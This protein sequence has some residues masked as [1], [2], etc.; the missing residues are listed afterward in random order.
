[1][2]SLF[3]LLSTFARDESGQDIIEYAL[4]ATVIALGA[5]ASMKSVAT[6]IHAVF[7]SVGTTLTNAT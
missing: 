3:H 7:S 2:P 4:L 1:M 6:G 5:I